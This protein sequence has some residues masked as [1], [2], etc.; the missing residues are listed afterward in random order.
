L[1]GNLKY[2]ILKMEFQLMSKLILLDINSKVKKMIKNEFINR[3]I[4]ELIEKKFSHEK[5]EELNL[6]LDKFIK[7]YER[8]YNI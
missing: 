7:L 8:E 5:N 3:N 6:M 4:K 2:D 1:F